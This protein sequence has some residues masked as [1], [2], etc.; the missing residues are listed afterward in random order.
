MNCFKIVFSLIL[1]LSFVLPGTVSALPASVEPPPD[2]NTYVVEIPLTGAMEAPNPAAAQKTEVLVN[3]KAN[4]AAYVDEGSP[5]AKL[6]TGAQGAYLRVGTS[7]EFGYPMWT[8]LSF[9][10]VKK[11]QG[12]PLPND[13]EITRARIKMYKESGAS[14]TV[15]VHSISDDFNEST[16]NWGNKPSTSGGALA[17]KSVPSANGWCYF[18]LPA[19]A[20]TMFTNHNYPV[21]LALKPDWTNASKSIAFHSDEHPSL[22]PV[23]VI[24]CWGS[25]P[26]GAAPAPSTPTPTPPPSDT[27]SC[28]LTYTVSPTHPTPGQ[29][30]T[31]T[32]TATDDHAMYYLTIM[33]GSIELARRDATSGQRE[34]T[35]SYTETAQLPS[36]N[37]QLFAD[38][39]G[40]AS[41]VSRTVTVPVTGSGTAPTVT[42]TA[43]WV[44]VERVVPNTFRLIKNDGQ[45]VLITAEASDPD[46]IR[47]LHISINGIDHPFNY[48]DETSVSESVGWENDQPSRTR[49]YYRAYAQDLEGQTTS[50]EGESFD[51]AQPQDIR[52]IWDSATSIQNFG[53]DDLGLDVTWDRMCQIFG[54]GECWSV[55]SWGW[56]NL[57]AESYW[58]G[59]VRCSAGGGQCFGFAT[60]AAELYHGRISPS[61]L[62]MPHIASEL[63][64]NNGY[65][66]CWIQARQ[67]GQMG[68]EVAI[69]RYDRGNMGGSATLSWVESALESNDP[70]VVGIREGDG[71][72]AVTPWMIR[73][74]TDGTARIYIC[75][76][77]K[78]SGVRDANADIN[79]FG[80]YPYIVIDGDD[81]SYQWNSTTV[82]NDEIYYFTY[83]EACGDMDE[84]VDNP[85]LGSGAPYLTDH[86]IPSI[87]DWIAAFLTSGA[88]AY[89]EDE[90]GNVTGIYQG[91]LREEIPGSMA[92]IP[93]MGGSFTDLEM[94]ILPKDKKVKIH[95]EG[96]NDGEYDLN[97]MGDGTLYSIKKKKTL[98]GIEDL[99]LFEPSAGTLNYRF[100][101]MPG[102]AD[103]NFEVVIAA[104][105]AG[106]VPSL[107]EESVDREY[108]M[109]DVSCSE[110]C[111]FSVSVEEDGSTLVVDNYG[112]DITFDAVTRSTESADVV[113]PNTDPG[114]IPSSVQEDITVEE[115]RRVEITP[116]TW[117]SDEAR[118][119][120]RT[121]GGGARG[122]GGG[123]PWIPVIIGVAVVAV[124]GA[125][126][127]VLFGKGILGKK[128]APAKKAPKGTTKKT[129]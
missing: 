40:P 76:S 75:D 68:E 122:E 126:L 91:Q 59:Y 10:P 105:F 36:M 111:D 84:A 58:D 85:T 128:A 67:A 48:T 63:T 104:I 4:K 99:F 97:L 50:A 108:A 14:G 44:D 81:F 66:G 93:M 94:Y 87:F 52:M 61:Q 46:G 115:G 53:L 21:R 37:Y 106:S 114:Y 20:V 32:A 127:G 107:D 2:N 39:L 110:G 72:H 119:A 30:V 116:E 71:G 86:D 31:I 74:M 24:Y 129:K 15:K 92:V 34:L 19:S 88:D 118:G 78:V 65:T 13:A 89:F 45:Q 117:D 6:G 98:R 17:T 8:L 22:G 7:P 62:E 28:V 56:K 70:G 69:P 11:A 25:A 82:W 96:T 101:V 26:A 54:D 51:I 102:V 73:Y 9:S 90:E 35:A 100:R 3:V 18:D 124:V 33:R 95:V 113:D 5:N 79:T 16:V 123:F 125:V 43:E 103:D 49:F 83:Q 80:D 1:L 60:L 120:L 77:N 64:Y 47:N 112:D 23:L 121:I 42:V 29:Q 57:I 55:E 27:A 109:E 12:G 38:D 41:P